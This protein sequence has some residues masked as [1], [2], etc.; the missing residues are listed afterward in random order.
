MYWP[1]R[2]WPRPKRLKP[3]L[4]IAGDCGQNPCRL[5]TKINVE[6]SWFKRQ[7]RNK[8]TDEQTDTTDRITYL[9]NA[10]SCTPIGWCFSTRR[11]IFATTTGSTVRSRKTWSTTRRRGQP[12]LRRAIR[13]E[14]SAAVSRSAAFRTDSHRLLTCC[15]QHAR[16]TLS[17]RT[18]NL[19]LTVASWVAADTLSAVWQRECLLRPR[20]GSAILW[21]AFC[22]SVREHI[23]E[24]TCNYLP[25]CLSMLP[26]ALGRGSDLLWRCCNTYTSIPVLWMSSY[27]SLYGGM[28]HI[29]KYLLPKIWDFLY[30]L[31][32]VYC[33]SYS[34]LVS[35]NATVSRCLGWRRPLFKMVTN[36]PVHICSQREYSQTITD[37]VIIWIQLPAVLWHCWLGVRKSIRL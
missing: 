6:E 11:R 34:T 33:G 28:S 30:S 8:R 2:L 25:N 14:I 32:V 21:R 13:G 15:S 9:A 36:L 16:R 19:P 29:W 24:T 26:N 35:L 1:L 7:Y 10:L 31:T 12:S 4:S 18:V 5:H 3:R 20:R 23:S 22:G 27:S 37:N 17:C